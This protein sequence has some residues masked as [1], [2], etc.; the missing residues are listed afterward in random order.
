MLGNP[1][2]SLIKEEFGQSLSLA[3]FVLRDGA[4]DHD[5]AMASNHPAL[6][7]HFFD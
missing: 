7:T 2:D 1:K 6:V 5:P 4:N 3:L